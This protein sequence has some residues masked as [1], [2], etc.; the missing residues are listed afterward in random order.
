M[1]SVFTRRA[2]FGEVAG[3]SQSRRVWTRFFAS[4]PRPVERKHRRE[5]LPP[6]SLTTNTS[7]TP[8]PPSGTLC[9]PQTT[10]PAPAVICPGLDTLREV[11]DA[12]RV[13]VVVP[14]PSTVPA[15][16]GE[17]TGTGPAA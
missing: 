2:L 9:R 5:R 12:W 15:E 14:G 4:R 13:R 7:G 3:F 17:S 10:D 1:P 16:Y 6:L 11:R 8:C